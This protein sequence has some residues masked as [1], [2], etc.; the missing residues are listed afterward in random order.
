MTEHFTFKKEERLCS[1]ILI[2]KLFSTGET[3]LA[4]PFKVVFVKIP[5]KCSYPAQSSFSVSKRN[6]KQAVDRNRIKRLMREAF[7][8]NKPGFYDKLKA[9]DTQLA[10]MF[11]FIGKE[12]PTY[13]ETEK[14]IKNALHKIL[15]KAD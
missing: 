4:F 1:R 7:R 6:F 15:R 10:I 14:G 3:F 9:K 11:V 13:Q 12:I 8:L 5:L 2:E